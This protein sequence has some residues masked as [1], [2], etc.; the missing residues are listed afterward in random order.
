MSRRRFARWLG[1]PLASLVAALWLAPVFLLRCALPRIA[2]GAGGVI[3]VSGALP[4][5]PFGVQ[6]TH[7]R[8]AREG[9]ELALDDFRAVLGLSGPR[10]DARVANGTLLVRGDGLWTR[11]GFVRVQDVDLESLATVLAT[12]LGLRGRAGGVWHFGPD[13][14]LEGSV[15]RGA[16]L[17]ERP[18]PFELP[19]AQL[20]IQAARDPAA[21]D[22]NVRWLDVQGPPL[23][24]SATGTLTADGQIAFQ[25]DVRQLDEPVRG[26]F[27]MLRMPTEPL[28]LAF[29]LEGTLAAPRVVAREAT[30]QPATR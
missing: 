4:A 23:S 25:V 14:S 11:S 3:E 28:P 30:A 6:A 7:L 29:A 20:V 8:V 10:I 21:G 24:G 9:R 13:A 18:A 2:A 16:L 22:W 15:S 5:L 27:A 1:L 26:F 12:P 19:F 17:V